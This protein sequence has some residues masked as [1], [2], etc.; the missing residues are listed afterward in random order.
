MAKISQGAEH[1]YAGL[2]YS[3]MGPMA[4]L[5]SRK[6]YLVLI[7]FRSPEVTPIPYSQ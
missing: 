4:I 3:F 7:D 2:K 6:D 1:R 5:H